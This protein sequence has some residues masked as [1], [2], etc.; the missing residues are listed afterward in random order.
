MAASK[1]VSTS[2]VAA[3]TR[4]RGMSQWAPG[5]VDDGTRDVLPDLADSAI[6]DV[7][8]TPLRWCLAAAIAMAMGLFLIPTMR[9][10]AQP[11]YVV[12]T[13]GDPVGGTCAGGTGSF[14]QCLAAANSV[15]GS[16]ITFSVDGVF[17]LSSPATHTNLF[18]EGEVTIQG[19]GADRTI[20]DGNQGDHELFI[21]NGTVAT[22]SGVTLRNFRPVGNG[23]G[24]IV[25]AGRSLTVINSAISGNTLVAARDTPSSTDVIGSGGGIFSLAAL[26]VTGTTISGND[27]VVQ[28][29]TADRLIAQGG[30]LFALTGNAGNLGPVILTNVTISRNRL[31]L[32]PRPGAVNISRGAGIY[33]AFN[34]IRPA[35]DTATN[36]T[37]TANS[38]AMTGSGVENNASIT[39]ANSIIAGNTGAP[40]CTSGQSPVNGGYNLDSDRSCFSGSTSLHAD[41]LLGPLADNGG[42]TMTH[43]LQPGSPAVDSVGPGCPPPGA[44]QR[45]ITRPQGPACDMGAFEVVVPGGPPPTTTT[46]TG[47]TTTTSTLPATTTTTSTLPTTTTTSVPATT[48]TTAATT[49]TTAAPTITCSVTGLIAG[50]PKQQQVTVRS[51]AGLASVTSIQIVNGTVSVATFTVGTTGP[52]VVTATKADQARGTSWSFVANDVAGRSHLCA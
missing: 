49:T 2:W 46:T 25:N 6:L 20:I 33:G 42:P 13:T 19:N 38:G 45:G 30:G 5:D 23:G 26:T 52:V 10:H 9:A 24:A 43:A 31:L 11:T 36:V 12:N 15:P 8:R 29:A 47:A 18:V 22:I 17:T 51:S 39:F 16:L 14:R 32:T 1:P 40:Q 50:P 41:P 37:I 3:A 27:V 48:T 34:G 4:Q 28:D 7:M 35:N 44:D 21:D